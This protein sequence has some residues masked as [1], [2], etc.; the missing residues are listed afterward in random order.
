MGTG[1]LQ[2][3]GAGCGLSLGS[4]SNTQ[5]IVHDHSI[6]RLPPS[7]LSTEADLITRS[8]THVVI[9]CCSAATQ[10]KFPCSRRV[11]NESLLPTLQA[12]RDVQDMSF[13]PDGCQGDCN[14]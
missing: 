14:F 6:R 8:Q 12:P 13:L 10:R 4:M 11:M 7:A 3:V 9:Y 2:L 1:I 5:G